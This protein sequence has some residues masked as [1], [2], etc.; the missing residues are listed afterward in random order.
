VARACQ[1]EKERLVTQKSP[2]LPAV[3]ADLVGKLTELVAQASAAILAVAPHA[4]ATRIKPDHTPLT[5]ADEAADAIICEG[6]G[7]LLPGIAV[8]S[9]ERPA[10]AQA[11][12]E[13]IAIVDPL[14]GTKEFIAGLGEYT[15]NIALV[16]DGR[17][18]AGFIAAPALGLVFRGV[19]RH[20]AERLAL[21]GSAGPVAIRCRRNPAGRLVAAVSRSHPDAATSAFLDRLAVAERI[22]CG[23]ALK[24]CKIAEGIADLYPRLS[25]T[26][27]WDTAA[28]HAIVAAAGGLV[29]TPSGQS[30]RYGG[31][32]HGFR[33]PGFVAWGDSRR[34]VD[35]I[36]DGAGG[37]GRVSS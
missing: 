2:I 3:D 18:I 14:D 8:V 33:V 27:E 9:E 13:S 15:V 34:R 23:S 7:R 25:P 5:A 22:A 11:P 28:G 32:Q 36:T 10:G 12:G 24:F 19:E 6:L 20:G 35:A 29:T 30:L 37:R 16:T 21:V 31:W 1:G 17:P 26:S 4:L